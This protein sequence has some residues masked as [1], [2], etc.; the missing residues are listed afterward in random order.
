M[1]KAI[2]YTLSVL[3]IIFLIL[4]MFFKVRPTGYITSLL[5][6]FAVQFS[7]FMGVLV[8]GYC[9]FKRWKNALISFFAFMIFFSFYSPFLGGYDQGP[10][11]LSI[12]QFNVLKFNKDYESTINAALESDCDLISFQEVDENWEAFLVNGLIDEYP[13]YQVHSRS[14]CY[15]LAVFSKYPIS[16]TEVISYRG[17]PSLKGVIELKENEVSFIATHTRSP[18][19]R[20]NFNLRNDQIEH[21]AEEVKNVEGPLVVIGDFNS[22]P[23][24]QAIDK[25]KSNTHLEDSRKSITPTYPSFLPIAG[26]PIDFIFHSKDLKCVGFDSIKSTSSDHYGVIGKYAL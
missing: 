14:D 24:D 6:S 5:F 7:V 13:Y 26:I 8:I 19:S 3:P 16:E 22:V 4:A 25:F 21:L 15:G 23:W 9:I 10:T 2:N 17:F 1:K 12:A 18:I 20:N 11:D